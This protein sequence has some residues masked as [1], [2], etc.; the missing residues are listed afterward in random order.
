MRIIDA[1][2]HLWERGRFT[3]SWLS[4]VD[5]LNRDFLLRHY[6]AGAGRGGLGPG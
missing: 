3:Y 6:E 2:H 4:Q 5:A 1:H